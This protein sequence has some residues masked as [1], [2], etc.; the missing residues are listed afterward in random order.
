MNELYIVKLIPNGLAPPTTTTT[1]NADLHSRAHHTHKNINFNT[2]TTCTHRENRPNIS[3]RHS[4]LCPPITPV[5]LSG[6]GNE[7]SREVEESENSLLIPAELAFRFAA[8]LHP[9][10]HRRSCPTNQRRHTGVDEGQLAST[11]CGR[12]HERDGG[13]CETRELV[14]VKAWGWGG[15]S[16]GLKVDLWMKLV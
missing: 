14:A 2:V 13:G 12:M 7:E 9:N 15:G 6:C 5:L 11:R 8:G 1:T 3:F 4:L 16:F 10:R